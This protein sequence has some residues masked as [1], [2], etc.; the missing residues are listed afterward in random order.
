ME[1]GRNIC[2]LA[3]RRDCEE[4]LQR[5]SVPGLMSFISYLNLILQD[6]TGQWDDITS[7]CLSTLMNPWG[8]SV[9]RTF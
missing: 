9:Q 1:N 2:V 8:K 4:F 6:K 3:R 7:T 5:I